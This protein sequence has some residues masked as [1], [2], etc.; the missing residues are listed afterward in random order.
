MIILLIL[1]K[2]SHIKK[3]LEVYNSSTEK[4]QWGNNKGYIVQLRNRYVFVPCVG[5]LHT[6]N[7]IYSLVKEYKVDVVIRIGTCGVLSSDITLGQVIV[8][9][10]S[11]N[12]DALSEKYFS[13][14][15]PIISSKYV[16]QL[17]NS[18]GGEFRTTY[19]VDVLWEKPNKC[20]DVVDMETSALYC[21]GQHNGLDSVSVSVCRDNK[22]GRI[23]N[24]MLETTII[25]TVQSIVNMF[26]KL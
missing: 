3:I 4:D 1:E 23:S 11:I 7:T 18:I 14:E 21:F 25:K 9:E 26:E 16:D 15:K 10:K 2:Y 24:G 17:R 5:S 6:L 19:T 13:D 8:V 20:A 22:D 12:K